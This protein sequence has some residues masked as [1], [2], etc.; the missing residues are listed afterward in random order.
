MTQPNRLFLSRR[1]LLFALAALAFV[2]AVS[3]AAFLIVDARVEGVLNARQAAIVDSEIGLVKIIDAEEDTNALAR[4]ISRRAALPN[5]DLPIHA[6]I[7]REGH[8]LAGD[9]DWPS[10]VPT[11]GTWRAIETNKRANGDSVSGFGRAL[12]LPRSKTRVL[13][14]R[15]RGGQ[16]TIQ[17]AIGEAMMVALAT[18]ILVGVALLIFLNRRILGRIDTIVATANRI[19]AGNLHERIPRQDHDDEF[20]RLGGVLNAML[21]RNEAHID[22][23]RVVT[24]AI[25]HDL[26][27][28]LQRVK[29]DLERAQASTDADERDHAFARAEREMDGA[30]ATFNALI[31]ITRAQSGIGSDS[32]DDVDLAAVARDVVELFGPVAEDKAQTLRAQ[33][34]PTIVRGQGALLRQALGNLIQNAIKF[35]PEGATITVRTERAGETA[36]LIVEDTGPGIPED[37]RETALRPFGRLAR[38]SATEGKGLGLALV[39]ACAKLH[40]GVLRLEEARPGLRAILQLPGGLPRS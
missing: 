20:A 27:L 33:V 4:F 8:Q 18:L 14:G 30:L 17:S 36:N 26:R 31:E 1:E 11:D 6:L 9:V 34:S 13:I 19:A 32:F 35:S 2:A 3:V 15:E 38:D 37:Q 22:Q 12:Y 5:D 23:M 24:D 28:P 29:A 21:E 40:R 25:A 7:D 16:R 39:A 10:G